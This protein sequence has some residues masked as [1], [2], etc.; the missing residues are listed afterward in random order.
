MLNTMILKVLAGVL[1]N[2]A[3]VAPVATFDASNPVASCQAN[4]S[5]A[6]CDDIMPS[7]DDDINAIAAH[8]TDDAPCSVES[9]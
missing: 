7:D 1:L 3:P 9:L 5:L 6:E 8:A 4:P 2:T